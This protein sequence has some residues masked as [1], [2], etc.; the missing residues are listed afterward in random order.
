MTSCKLQWPLYGHYNTAIYSRLGFMEV[1]EGLLAARNTFST[2]FKPSLSRFKTDRQTNRQTRTIIIPPS[3]Y[4]HASYIIII[5]ISESHKSVDDLSHQVLLHDPLHQW[6]VTPLKAMTLQQRAQE[7]TT[8]TVGDMFA[9]GVQDQP[10]RSGSTNK[11]AKRVLLRLQEKLEGIE[12]GVPLS[13]SG[14]VTHL[15]QEASDPA[16][17]CLLFPGW[18]PWI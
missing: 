18:Q 12:D 17:L 2:V 11:M 7:D 5:K 8:S 10:T 14:Q 1:S 16:N 13:V 3:H 9:S 6:T 4:V 15:I